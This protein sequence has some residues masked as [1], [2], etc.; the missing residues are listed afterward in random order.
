MLLEDKTE[1][2]IASE[3]LYDISRQKSHLCR[4]V[5]IIKQ[6][7]SF[8]LNLIMMQHDFPAITV[9]NNFG[10]LTYSYC[11]IVEDNVH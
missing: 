6:M 10:S 11:F 8:K 7:P 3:I 2:S 5:S 9:A 4:C 1:Y